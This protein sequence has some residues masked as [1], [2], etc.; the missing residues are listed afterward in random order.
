[1]APLRWVKGRS[2][3]GVRSGHMLRS[4]RSAQW[5]CC[6]LF[7]LRQLRLLAAS[8]ELRMQSEAR[9]LSTQH[10]LTSSCGLARCHSMV[11]RKSTPGIAT[12]KSSIRLFSSTA[13][14]VL[15]TWGYAAADLLTSIVSLIFKSRMQLKSSL[16]HPQNKDRLFPT[17]T[18]LPVLEKKFTP[19]IG[20]RTH[21]ET[22]PQIWCTPR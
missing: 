7:P 10:A 12:S 15:K 14:L 22:S 18:S 11:R 13:F 20:S 3:K 2:Q 9:Y 4:H 8:T 17:S 21:P 6:K 16:N 5:Q 1:M 19:T